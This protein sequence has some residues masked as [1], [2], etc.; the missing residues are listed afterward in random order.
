MVFARLPT[1]V[2]PSVDLWLT[3][4][5]LNAAPGRIDIHVDG[6]MSAESPGGDALAESFTNLDGVS[7]AR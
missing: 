7:W 2:R 4:G 5:L 1:A 3:T 6:Y